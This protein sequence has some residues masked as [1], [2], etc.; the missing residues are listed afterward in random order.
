LEGGG[1]FKGPMTTAAAI[2]RL[3]HHST[4]PE[5]ENEAAGAKQA[6]SRRHV[7]NGHEDKRADERRRPA[8]ALQS[9]PMYGAQDIRRRL[10]EAYA[11]MSVP[12]ARAIERIL[13]AGGPIRGRTGRYDSEGGMVGI[14]YG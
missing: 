14:K 10:E 8:W 6:H 2:Y 1:I 11:V 12:S 4:I 9:G 7:R 5:P 13:V 3:L